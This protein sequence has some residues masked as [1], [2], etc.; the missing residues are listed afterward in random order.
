L[1]FQ[2]VAEKTAKDARGLLYFAAPGI[3]YHAELGRPRSNRVGISRGESQNT[4]AL[5]PRPL[6]MQDVADLVKT[7]P[8]QSPYVSPRQMWSFYIKGVA[9][10]RREPIR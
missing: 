5:G 7:S 4:G 9:I 1:K 3:C 8:S 10:N 6:V 2:A